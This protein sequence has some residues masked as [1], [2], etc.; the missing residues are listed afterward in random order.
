M[1]F[2]P[3]LQIFPSQST[4]DLFHTF[5]LG[6]EIIGV[7]ALL[8]LK[9]QIRIMGVPICSY[10]ITWY[11]FLHT[12]TLIA[13]GMIR[14]SIRKNLVKLDQS[15]ANHNNTVGV[16]YQLFQ[17][18]GLLAGLKMVIIIIPASFDGTIYSGFRMLVLLKLY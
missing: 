10:T 7:L 3:K 17:G 12:H 4:I 1:N 2:L 9:D 18:Q 8:V 6:Q 15:V 16:L 5:S 11:G 13:R 14:T